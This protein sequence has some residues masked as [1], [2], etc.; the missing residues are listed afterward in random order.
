MSFEEA[1]QHRAEWNAQQA[2]GAER[3]KKW[4][5]DW[6][7]TGNM[8]AES[9]W[10][11]PSTRN[12]SFLL[13]GSGQRQ[14]ETR[15]YDGISERDLITASI[16][17]L[18]DLGFNF[19]NSETELGTIIAS[20]Q[21]DTEGLEASFTHYLSHGLLFLVL[22]VTK[23]QITRVAIVVRPVLDSNGETI[24][25]SHLVRVTFQSIALRTNS[26]TSG[27]TLSDPEL[28]QGFFEKLSKSV[29]LEAQEI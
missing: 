29:F 12:P 15:R 18:Q 17:L 7:S 13:S 24:D 19:E 16:N 28:Y 2:A 14:I 8:P 3:Q 4:W 25:D 11:A 1:A 22:P 21:R 9:F 23:D 10:S 26:S 20:K 27:K 5:K 6:L